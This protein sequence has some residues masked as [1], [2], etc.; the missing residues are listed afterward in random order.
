MVG[1]C[2]R[3]DVGGRYG[4]VSWKGDVEGEMWKGIC[5][6]ISVNSDGRE[7]KDPSLKVAESALNLEA[8]SQHIPSWIE[9]R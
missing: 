8:I 5:E 7:Y 6:K 1:R 9:A 4:R 3:G 2:G